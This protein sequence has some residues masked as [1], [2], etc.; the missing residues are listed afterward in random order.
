MIDPIPIGAF[1]RT[2]NGVARPEDIIV[3]PDG[4]VLVSDARSAV[5][6]ILADGSIRRFGAAGGEPNGID[7]APDGTVLI[8]NFS[9]G[10]LQRLDLV[11]GPLNTVIN[12]VG[13][14]ART[15]LN[16]P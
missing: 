7:I 1:S 6:E 13:G 3:T 4:R 5:A 10:P 8:A 9:T 14:R 16:H 11:S 2:A 15:A 12:P